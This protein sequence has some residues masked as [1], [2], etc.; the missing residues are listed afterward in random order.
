MARSRHR[1]LTRGL[2]SKPDV[3]L[4]ED[5][6]RF[7]LEDEGELAF[8]TFTRRDDTLTL[9]HTDV[10]ERLEGQGVGTTLVRGALEY[11]KANHLKVVPR[12]PF[13]ATHLKRHPDEAA[14]VGIDPTTL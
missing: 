14:G 12:C 2:M 5:L 8:L 9:V 11:I 3:V 6:Q 1:A 10:P 4:N 13:V 7:E